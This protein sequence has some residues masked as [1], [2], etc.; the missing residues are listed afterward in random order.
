MFLLQSYNILLLLLF[1]TK[2]VFYSTV[3]HWIV[4]DNQCLP[5]FSSD[6]LSVM[7]MVTKL[8]PFCKIQ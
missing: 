4:E 2:H 3:V 6:F 8:A 7:F 5:H 1:A